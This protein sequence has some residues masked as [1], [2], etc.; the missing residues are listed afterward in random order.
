MVTEPGRIADKENMAHTPLSRIISVLQLVLIIA[1][2]SALAALAWQWGKTAVDRDAYRQRLARLQDDYNHLAA[3]Y[4]QAIARTAVCEVR[5]DAGKLRVVVRTADGQ[6][7][8]HPL[9]FDP[10]RE[11]HFDFAC[12]ENRLQIRRV[13]DDLTPPAQGALIQSKLARIDWGKHT[14]DRGLVLYRP[15]PDGRYTVQVS[16]NGALTLEPLDAAAIG[17]L[18]HAPLLRRFEPAEPMQNAD[19]RPGILDIG[20]A[21]IQK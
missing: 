12:L 15:V 13:Y 6:T 3:D 10:A 2:L 11:I 14:E 19:R 17:R 4:N 16:G 21:L 8:E 7:E 20:R 1:G 18:E 9:P 5:S